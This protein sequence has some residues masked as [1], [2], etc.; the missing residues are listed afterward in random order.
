M[1]FVGTNWISNF[2]TSQ[3]HRMLRSPLCL[4]TLA[5]EA[6]HVTAVPFFLSLFRPARF[7]SQASSRACSLLSRSSR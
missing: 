6:P 4:C 2:P 5:G 3:T 1:V 7:L